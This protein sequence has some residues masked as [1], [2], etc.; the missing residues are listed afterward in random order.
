MVQ[1]KPLFPERFY[2]YT[3]N[4]IQVMSFLPVYYYFIVLSFLV[5]LMIYTTPRFSYLKLFP[6]FLLTTLAVEYVGSYLN[7]KGVNNLYIYNFFSA[8]EFSFYLILISLMVKSPRMK[9]GLVIASVAYAAV[10]FT[11]IIFIQG[12]KTLHTV[13]YSLGCLAIVAA[14]FYYFY[15]LFRQ[16]NAIK[17]TRNPAFWICS[18]LLFFYCCGFPLYAF[19]NFWFRYK[20]MIQSFEDIVMILNIFLYSLFTIAFLCSRTRKSISSSS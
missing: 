17:L 8:L 13:T 19:V 1:Q 4:E 11:N 5:S 20:W 18:G 14:C 6:P 15:E 9:K 7:Y 10:A 2:F 3:F 12:M 16:R